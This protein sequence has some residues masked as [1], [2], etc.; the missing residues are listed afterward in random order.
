MIAF[1][2]IQAAGLIKLLSHE[3]HYSNNLNRSSAIIAIGA[4]TLADIFEPAERGTKAR[5]DL[6][7]S[8]FLNDPIKS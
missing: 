5:G 7:A 6:L 2:A 3:T 1:R 8:S 4:A